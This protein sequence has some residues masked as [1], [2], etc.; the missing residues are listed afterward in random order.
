MRLPADST[1]PALW[2]I[3]RQDWLLSPKLVLR[4]SEMSEVTAMAHAITQ[5]DYASVVRQPQIYR[6]KR[7]GSH[8]A[9][10]SVSNELLSLTRQR[11][12]GHGRCYYARVCLRVWEREGARL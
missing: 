8:G 12:P 4:S 7:R 9:N 3:A 1:E 2:C 6:M 11:D 5:Q 10:A